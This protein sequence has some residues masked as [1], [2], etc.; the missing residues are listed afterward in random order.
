[1]KRVRSGCLFIAGGRKSED[2]YISSLLL[3]LLHLIFNLR[4]I[5]SEKGKVTYMDT[6][7]SGKVE[8]LEPSVRV[9][10]YSILEVENPTSGKYFRINIYQIP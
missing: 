3:P 5:T 1:M 2:H 10:V 4:D 8:S 7:L 6:G 9:A